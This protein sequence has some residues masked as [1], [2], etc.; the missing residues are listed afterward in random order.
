MSKTA[1]RLS[2]A[3]AAG[4]MRLRLMQSRRK[5]GFKPNSS[6]GHK[7]YLNGQ[8]SLSLP[9]TEVSQLLSVSRKDEEAKDEVDPHNLVVGL[10]I[11]I[12]IPTNNCTI[13]MLNKS[14]SE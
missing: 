7:S 9:Q 13:Q 1:N 14:V 4:V 10:L 11:I 5:V 2:A 6:G 3:A 12:I 8:F